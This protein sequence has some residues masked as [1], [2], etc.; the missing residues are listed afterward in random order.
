MKKFR[1]ISI[2]LLT[3]IAHCSFANS[4]SNKL[5]NLFSSVNTIQ[6]HF[7]QTVFGQ[8]DHA[9]ATS[10]GIF[11]IKRP[12][13]F[14][15]NVV[16]PMQQLTIADG[17]RIW[18]YQPDLQQVTVSQMRKSMGHTPLAILSGSTNV[19]KQSYVITQPNSSTFNLKSKT[20]NSPF[21]TI[22]LT[23]AQQKITQMQLF[24]ALG[25]KT[26]INFADVS[27]NAAI[28]KNAFQFVVPKGVDV[29]K[30]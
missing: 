26:I 19:L 10:K 5:A 6:G 8:D 4:P 16:S 25:Q 29:I 7:T 27:L 2:L 18:L 1:L 23:F 22:I 28:K 14:R 20:Q 17:Q 9:M 13:Q 21:Q 24:D 12:N 15:W 11:I 3:L 30:G